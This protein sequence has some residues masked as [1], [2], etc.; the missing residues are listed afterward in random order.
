MTGLHIAVSIGFGLIGVAI[1]YTVRRLWTAED[2]MR[3]K[4]RQ[5]QSRIDGENEKR[6]VAIED[7]EQRLDNCLKNFASNEGLL[8]LVEATRAVE[9]TYYAWLSQQANLF[10]V[11]WEDVARISGTS[12]GS[13]K[14]ELPENIRKFKRK[15]KK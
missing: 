11:V 4:R 2:D 3:R 8:A 9:T 1:V 10:Y 12:N 15:K 5:I 7:L 13:F 6:A 14:Y